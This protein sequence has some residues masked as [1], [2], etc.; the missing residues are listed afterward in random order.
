MTAMLK[1]CDRCDATVPEADALIFMDYCASCSDVLCDACMAEG[2]CGHVP[3]LSGSQADLAMFAD[4][5]IHP[6]P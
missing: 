4:L 6:D 1:Q 2:C 3:A 5:G